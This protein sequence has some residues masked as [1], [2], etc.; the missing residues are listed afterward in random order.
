M[1]EKKSS[2]TTVKQIQVAPKDRSVSIGV[3]QHSGIS[4]PFQTIVEDIPLPGMP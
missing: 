2:P 3:S 4:K 1:S